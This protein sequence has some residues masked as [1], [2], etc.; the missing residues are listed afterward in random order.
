MS[1]SAHHQTM[2]S[3]ILNNLQDKPEFKEP[4]LVVGS[5]SR[6]RPRR[7]PAKVE[8]ATIVKPAIVKP[9]VVTIQGSAR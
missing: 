8:T 5:R 7:G 1:S 2:L 6:V 9:S 3:G 4:I